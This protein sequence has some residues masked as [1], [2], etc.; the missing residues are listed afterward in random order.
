MNW[1][2][3]VPWNIVG[4][5]MFGACMFGLGYWIKSRGVEGI[6]SDIKDVKA[7]LEHIKASI[8]VAK[9]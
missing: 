7:D 5:E 8:N 2:S 3:N 6:W 4:I 9:N 1:L